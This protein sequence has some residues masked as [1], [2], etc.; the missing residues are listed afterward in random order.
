[1]SETKSN[2]PVKRRTTVFWVVTA[3]CALLWWA[4]VSFGGSV[5]RVVSWASLP[6]SVLVM[7]WIYQFIRKG[8]RTLYGRI[9]VATYYGWRYGLPSVDQAEKVIREAFAW[10]DLG[11]FSDE[12]IQRE[13]HHDGAAYIEKRNEI[14]H[15]RLYPRSGRMRSLSTRE[16]RER[17]IWFLRLYH[18]D[19]DEVRNADDP[20]L[21]RILKQ[22]FE[23]RWRVLQVALENA[24]NPA[25]QTAASPYHTREAAEYEKQVIST[26][27]DGLA[28]IARCKSEKTGE[29]DEIEQSSDSSEEKDRRRAGV[30]RFWDTQINA[31]E[32]DMQRM[33]EP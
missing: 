19:L 22:Y 27:R 16:D 11:R 28:Y 32:R 4:T 20:T 3:G 9:H 12:M 14:E 8:H 31:A 33:M 5:T 6:I 1:M 21:E 29:L 24:R 15:E 13:A 26:R 17:F 10:N 2:D 7:S 23:Y 30:I 25:P 18:P